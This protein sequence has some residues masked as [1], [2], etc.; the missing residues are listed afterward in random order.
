[1]C[2]GDGPAAHGG[3]KARARAFKVDDE[4]DRPNRKKKIPFGELLFRVVDDA[5]DESIA[6]HGAADESMS[7]ENVVRF[8]WW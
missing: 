2:H 7:L 4:I 3:S 6:R 1:M 8:P 5:E